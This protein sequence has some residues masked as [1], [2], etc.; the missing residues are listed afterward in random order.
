MLE[1]EIRWLQFRMVAVSN[2]KGLMLINRI[3]YSEAWLCGLA[4]DLLEIHAM[5]SG[6]KYKVVRGAVL[7]LKKRL[8]QQRVAVIVLAVLPMVGSLVVAGIN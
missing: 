4:I 7:P 8:Q 6:I 1:I 2:A 3:L 5:N